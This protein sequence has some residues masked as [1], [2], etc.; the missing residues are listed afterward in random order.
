MEFVRAETP[1]AE[2]VTTF[3]LEQDVR[4][5]PRLADVAALLGRSDAALFCA[6][7]EGRIKGLAAGVTEGPLCHL[8]HF[9]IAGDNVDEHAGRLIELVEQ[10]AREAGAAILA[11]QAEC[12]S[13]MD[14]LL[15]SFGF[16][17]DWQ[18]NDAVRGRVVTVVHLL[19]VL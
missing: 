15:R 12:G 13:D 5:A 10:S 4:P 11:A 1:Q 18:E 6:A 17:V 16:S 14:R 7:H 8:I 3:L 2:S 9:L 19:K